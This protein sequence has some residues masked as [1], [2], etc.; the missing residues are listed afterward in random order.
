MLGI[1]GIGSIPGLEDRLGEVIG[2][3][4][5]PEVKEIMGPNVNLKL[6]YYVLVLCRHGSKM[7]LNCA[8]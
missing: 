6:S 5:G 4:T 7:V 1:V 8:R 3:A 2:L